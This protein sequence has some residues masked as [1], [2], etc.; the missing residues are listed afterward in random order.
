M[1]PGA[2]WSQ[3]MKRREPGRLFVGRYLI[4][5]LSHLISCIAANMYAMLAAMTA[6]P[7]RAVRES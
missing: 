5:A 7:I 2:S 6:M 4:T 3:A 1:G